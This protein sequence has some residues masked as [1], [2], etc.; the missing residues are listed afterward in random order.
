MHT[1][2]K[3]EVDG[4]G[5]RFAHNTKRR[6]RVSGFRVAIPVAGSYCY[7]WQLFG[8]FKADSLKF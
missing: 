2:H 1:Q 8:C 3:K 6:L 7:I 4:L 5:F